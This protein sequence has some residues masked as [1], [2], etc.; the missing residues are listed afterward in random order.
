VSELSAGILACEQS[1]CVGDAAATCLDVGW[2][3]PNDRNVVS[4]TL[5][6]HAVWDR[7]LNEAY[8]DALAFM[9]PDDKDA[10]AQSPLGITAAEQLRKAQRAWIVFRDENCGV[11]Y[12]LWG[13]GS[14]R[15]LAAAD[16]QLGMT[17]ERTFTLRR[18]LETFP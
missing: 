7:L 15:H 14:M 16:C 2:D 9:Q 4:C 6:E 13:N 12:V 1:S 17:A 5:N 11:L 10:P 18:Y 3:D 8:Q